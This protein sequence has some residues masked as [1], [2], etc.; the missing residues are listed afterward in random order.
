MNNQAYD[1][2]ATR[3]PRKAYTDYE[4]STYTVVSK[5]AYLIGVQKRIFENEYEPPKMEW[6]EK[7]HADKNARI[8]RNLCMIRTALELNFKA[9]NN[10]MRFDMCNLHSLPEYVPQD[11]LNELLQDGITIVRSRAFKVAAVLR[12]VR[13]KLDQA[14]HLNVRDILDEAC[15]ATRA[16]MTT[17]EKNQFYDK[18]IKTMHVDISPNGE[19]TIVLGK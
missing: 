3:N 16:D 18:Y 6:Y 17:A 1:D 7:L 12:E 10:R 19:A 5:V 15:R 4:N 14:F 11:S 13:Q 9:I 2:T 8:V